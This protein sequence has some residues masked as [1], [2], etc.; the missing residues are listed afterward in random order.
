MK[1]VFLS[2]KY[3][4]DHANR[5]LVDEI[6]TALEKAGWGSFCVARDVEQ[7]G[8]QSYPANELMRRTFSAIDDCT[9]VLVELSEKGVGVGIEAGYATA[10]GKPVFAVACMPAEISATL[11]GIAREVYSYRE[12]AD[13]T[14]WLS[15]GVLDAGLRG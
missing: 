1:T 4:E 15:S 14:Q 12:V 11:R 5:F 2:I 13:L 6:S 3:H 7:W 9:V 10:H 8:K